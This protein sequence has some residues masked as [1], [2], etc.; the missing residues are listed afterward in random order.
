[1]LV[2]SMKHPTLICDWAIAPLLLLTKTTTMK[3]LIIVWKK[4]KSNL[5]LA[6][7]IENHSGLL[8]ETGESAFVNTATMF[9]VGDT[10]EVDCEIE[11]TTNDSGFPKWTKA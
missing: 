10:V 1:M 8:L 3:T 5:A 2:Y 9:K 4:A 11:V 6:I 7:A